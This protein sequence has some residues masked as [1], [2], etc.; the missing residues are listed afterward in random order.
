VLAI[1]SGG[2]GGYG[3]G[4]SRQKYSYLPEALNDSI[5]AVM[6]EELGFIRV[7]RVHFTIWSNGGLRF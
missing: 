6:A 1:G 7:E 4:L 3:Y 2:L 5:F